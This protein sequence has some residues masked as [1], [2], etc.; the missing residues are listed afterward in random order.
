MK[1]IVCSLAVVLAA[2]TGAHA[3]DKCHLREL[4]LCA[5]TASG[6]TKVPATED[7]ID[8]YCAIG[9]EAKEC[10]EN[11]M[12]QCATPIQKELFSWVT[13]DPLKQGADFCKKGNALRNEYLKH[14]PCLAKAQPEGKKC[15][16]DIRAGLEKLESSKFTDRVSTACCIYHR[17]QKCSSEIV[18]AKCGKEALELGS[19]ILQRSVGVSVS[20]FCNG[21]DADSAQCQALLPPPG[22]KPSGNSKSIVSRLFS[23]YVSS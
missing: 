1:L 12:N 22:T 20:L 3:A 8:K 17:Y 15:V 19:N 16:E 13:K 10:V 2:L 11:Y 21:F 18:E 5:A 14:G 23:V 9:V 7:E 6:A 4:D